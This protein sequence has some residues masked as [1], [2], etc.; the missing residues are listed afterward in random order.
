MKL[1]KWKQDGQEIVPFTSQKIKKWTPENNKKIP[2]VTIEML[3]KWRHDEGPR[4]HFSSEKFK[5]WKLKE[6]NDTK[7]TLPSNDVVV[8]G[9]E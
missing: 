1:A 2:N 5:I 6:S 4:I 3:D 8:T 7:V 9:G